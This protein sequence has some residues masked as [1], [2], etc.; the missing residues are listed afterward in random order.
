LTIRARKGAGGRY[1]DVWL[2]GE[3]RMVF[4]GVVT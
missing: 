2:V 1:E 3:G 4:R